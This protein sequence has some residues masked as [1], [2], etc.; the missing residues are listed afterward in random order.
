MFL[1]CRI[2][3][4]RKT[5]VLAGNPLDVAPGVADTL[6]EPLEKR[7]GLPR[8]LVACS[9]Q[10]LFVKVSVVFVPVAEWAEN[11]T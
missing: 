6:R 3:P 8:C 9:G 4:S 5:Q 7:I 2:A 10:P 11:G 1:G